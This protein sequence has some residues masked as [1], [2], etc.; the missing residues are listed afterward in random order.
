LSNLNDREALLN[1]AN[2]W[3]WAGDG[4]A[5]GRTRVAGTATDRSSAL[6]PSYR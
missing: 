4:V 6:Q 2:A 5:T 3:E 1:S